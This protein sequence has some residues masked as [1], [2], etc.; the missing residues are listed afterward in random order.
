MDDEVCR[1]ENGETMK[2][3]VGLAA[4]IAALM[5]GCGT[6]EPGGVP[7]PTVTVT[8]MH[9]VTA[10]PEPVDPVEEASSG[11]VTP[12][13]TPTVTTATPTKSRRG[14]L[15]KGIGEQ[16]GLINQYGEELVL[17]TVTAIDPGYQCASEPENGQFVA[18]T[19][20][21]A[22]TEAL[23]E[24]DWPQVSFGSWTVVGADG[25]QQNADPNTG[26]A[27]G[28]TPDAERFPSP[29]GPGVTAEGVIVLDVTPE[30]GVLILDMG[31]VAGGWEWSF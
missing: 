9:T 20:S 4:V 12:E 19:I 28:C 5:V 13:T 25:M 24:E 2:R 11:G 26:S 15:V 14:G 21:A 30:S 17:F 7:P 27:W 18:L 1:A 31:T 8:V 6:A 22:T 29:I 16:A 23:A 3:N 10:T